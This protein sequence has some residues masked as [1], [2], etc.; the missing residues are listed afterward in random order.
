MDRALMSG[1]RRAEVEHVASITRRLAEWKFAAAILDHLDEGD[2]I[3]MDGLLD[4]NLKQEELYLAEL[5]RS[6]EEHGVILTG[7]SKTSAL[8]TTTGLSLIAA[9]DKLAHDY[10]IRG[11]WYYPI[12]ESSEDNHQAIILAVKLN[13]LSER[14]YIYEITLKQYQSLSELRR[15]VILS[16]L[17][18]NS[19]DITLPGYPYGLINADRL[20]RVSMDEIEYYRGL[21]ISVMDTTGRLNKFSRYIRAKDTHSV[22]NMLIR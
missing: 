10:E 20:A 11:E 18:H 6:A 12:A 9:V 13:P 2:V 19:S 3:V 5:A 16:Q 1:N 21:V 4:T 7:L 22:L 14:V 15:N 8:F 17:V